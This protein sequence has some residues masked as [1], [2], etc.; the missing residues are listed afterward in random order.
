LDRRHLNRRLTRLR[1]ADLGHLLAPLL[2][3]ASVQLEQGDRDEAARLLSEGEHLWTDRLVKVQKRYRKCWPRKGAV[4]VQGSRLERN[5]EWLEAPVTQLCRVIGDGNDRLIAAWGWVGVVYTLECVDYAKTVAHEGRVRRR[6]K[7]INVQEPNEVLER[8]YPAE[9]AA[10]ENRRL[11]ASGPARWRLSDTHAK[12]AL[13]FAE[14]L[15]GLRRKSDVCAVR[16]TEMRAALRGHLSELDLNAVGAACKRPEQRVRVFQ[17]LLGRVELVERLKRIELA[18][19]V[20]ARKIAF[21]SSKLEGTS[22]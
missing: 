17:Q 6:M 14:H 12:R 3:L 20:I 1:N 10:Y 4:A 2:A 18:R 15:R 9:F 21:L 22:E 16:V 7:L 8:D 11:A 5:L 13:Y 19:D